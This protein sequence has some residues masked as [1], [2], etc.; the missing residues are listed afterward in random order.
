MSWK[1]LI[2]IVTLML[3][4]QGSNALIYSALRMCDSDNCDIDLAYTGGMYNLTIPNAYLQTH[5]TMSFCARIRTAVN[6]S[7]G[8]CDLNGYDQP[9]NCLLVKSTYTST[10]AITLYTYQ[11]DATLALINGTVQFNTA[12]YTSSISLSTTSIIFNTLTTNSIYELTV[13]NSQNLA[14]DSSTKLVFFQTF[15]STST[16]GFKT[17]GIF[18]QRYF[19]CFQYYVNTSYNY[20]LIFYGGVVRGGQNVMFIHFVSFLSLVDSSID[21]TSLLNMWGG[22]DFSSGHAGRDMVG[23]SSGYGSTY[24][25]YSLYASAP[26]NDTSI[27]INATND[28][29]QV[30]T[31]NDKG[32]ISSFIVAGGYRLYDTLDVQG[33]EII[34]K[35]INYNFCFAVAYSTSTTVAIQP[36]DK[37]KHNFVDCW[38]PNII[39]W[40]SFL[41]VRM[42]VLL[43][44]LAYFI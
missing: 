10:L 41:S 35:K 11:A 29:T 44:F 7:N 37:I 38:N 16:T 27:N 25:L 2:A 31:S 19:Q 34:R 5:D 36:T 14:T 24:D 33:D 28:F 3:L 42:G 6:A 26:F 39:V 17:N 40:E 32:V 22:L 15:K 18:M 8:T 43:L 9:Y 1:L 13:G 30:F 12:S 23:F 4:L 20:N 21:T